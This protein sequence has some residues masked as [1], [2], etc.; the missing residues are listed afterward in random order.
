MALLE[1][2]QHFDVDRYLDVAVAAG[3]ELVSRSRRMGTEL[4]LFRAHG[5]GRCSAGV[6]DV[7]GDPLAPRECQRARGEGSRLV[8]TGTGGASIRDA[9][10]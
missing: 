3:R 9:G 10:R 4:P 7:T 5:H 6:H 1:A 8:S 2:H